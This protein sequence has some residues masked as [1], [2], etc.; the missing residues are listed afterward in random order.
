MFM[1]SLYT[2]QAVTPIFLNKTGA[3]N[4]NVAPL[5]GERHGFAVSGNRCPAGRG[6]PPAL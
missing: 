1:I 3:S 4:Q 5:Q 2:A 6:H